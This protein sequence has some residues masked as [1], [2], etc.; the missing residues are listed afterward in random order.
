MFLK[1][2]GL[3]LHFINFKFSSDVYI[4]RGANISFQDSWIENILCTKQT[5]KM[6]KVHSGDITLVANIFYTLFLIFIRFKNKNFIL[7]LS[8]LLVHLFPKIVFTSK[9]KIY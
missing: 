4:F 3:I 9:N 1:Q 6:K 7:E 5:K 2:V 8:S